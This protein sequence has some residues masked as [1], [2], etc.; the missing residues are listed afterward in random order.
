[1]TARSEEVIDGWTVPIHQM[2]PDVKGDILEYLLHTFPHHRHGP[3]PHAT[4]IRVA[5]VQMLDPDLVT[6]LAGCGTAGFSS[7]PSNTPR[8]I[9]RRA[10]RILFTRGKVARSRTDTRPAR[11]KIPNLQTYRKGAGEKIPDWE[12]LERSIYGIEVSRQMMRISMMNLVLHG[13]RNAH[14]K[15]R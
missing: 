10:A 7:T 1:L 6:L 9:F 5:M 14:V 13:I 12:L 2:G 15:R 3:V 11:K 8:E 4:Q